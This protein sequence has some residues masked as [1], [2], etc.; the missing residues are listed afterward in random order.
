MLQS[1]ETILEHFSNKKK[2]WEENNGNHTAIKTNNLR[3]CSGSLIIS[4]ERKIFFNYTRNCIA[5][6]KIVHCH[7]NVSADS[8]KVIDM[9]LEAQ[10]NVVCLIFMAN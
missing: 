10:F 4:L 8:T 7:V 2:K 6:N 5:K 1:L 3:P 9:H